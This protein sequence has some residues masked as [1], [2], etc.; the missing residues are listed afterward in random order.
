MMT[1]RVYVIRHGESETNQQ[2]RWTGWVDVHLTEN[3]KADAKRAGAM[4]C[5]IEFDKVFVSDLIRAIETAEIALPNC[6]YE[7]S[8]CLREINVGTLADKPLSIVTDGQ[9]ERIAEY[10]YVDFNGESNEQFSRRVSQMMHELESLGCETVALFTHAGWMRA[11]LDEVVGSYLPRKSII[12]NNCAVA[13]FECIDGAY[14][15]HS[16]INL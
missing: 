12:C 11:M 5:G 1:V 14:K 8:P 3:G 15:L 6:S 7:T 13:I 9:R 10:G 16:W 2:K 4:L